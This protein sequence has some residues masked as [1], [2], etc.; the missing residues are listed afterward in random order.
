MVKRL[1][2][3]QTTG[4][5]ARRRLTA[6]VR[7]VPRFAPTALCMVRTRERIV[8]IATRRRGRPITLRVVVAATRARARKS[9]T[10]T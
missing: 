8:A 10:A 1:I 4:D 6:L 7:A 5:L 9:R 3:E 2:D